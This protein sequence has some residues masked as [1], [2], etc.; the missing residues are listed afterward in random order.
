MGKFISFEGIDGSGKTTAS[1]KLYEYLL[2]LNIDAI[3]TREIGG[4]EVAEKI[5][6]IV[7]NNDMEDMTEIMLIMAARCENIE[8]IIKPALSYGKYVI[9]DRYIDSTAA[10]QSKNEEEMERIFSLHDH[11]FNGFL[12]SRT[13]YMKIDPKIALARATIRGDTNKFEAKPEDF[14]HKVTNNYDYLADRFSK[15]ISIIDASQTQEQ[16]IDD[17]IKALNLK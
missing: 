1:K 6:D 11:I 3:W 12:P 9:C 16:V 5:R 7:V 8:K 14:Y 4:T 13:I 2:S 17:V 15:R 10:Y